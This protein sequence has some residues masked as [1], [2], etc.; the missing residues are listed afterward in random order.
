[1]V[2]PV[3][4]VIVNREVVAGEVV[5]T[6][7][8]LFIV[9]DTRQMWLTLNLR[10]EDA[11]RVALGQ[12][13]RFLVDGSLQESQ[14]T[15]SW[16]SPEVDE[17][18]RTVKVRA[19]LANNEGR[20]RANSFG[21]GQIILRKENNAL[22]VPN[23]AV[24]WEGDCTVVF[25]R[26]K[27]YL[28]QDAPKVFHVRQVRLGAKDQEN[29]EIIAGVLPGELVATKGSGTLRAELLKNNLGEG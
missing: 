27:N 11:N 13:I 9:A 29:T 18:T 15:V 5:D 20:L 10:Q 25:V 26:D 23:E 14:G 8:T 28:S 17:K 22:V 21:Q 4:G 12:L 2:S 19:N 1:M 24:H 3:A 16:I 7:K 6:A